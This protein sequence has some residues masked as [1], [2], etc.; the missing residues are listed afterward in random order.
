[1]G[2]GEASS[3]GRRGGA[4]CCLGSDGCRAACARVFKGALATRG[5]LGRLLNAGVLT[6]RRNRRPEPSVAECV[7]WIGWTAGWGREVVAVAL[8]LVGCE[9]D[10]LRFQVP[11]LPRCQVGEP[12]GDLTCLSCGARLLCSSS[13]LGARAASCLDLA[14]HLPVRSECVVRSTMY[15]G[16]VMVQQC[17][18]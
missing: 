2:I 6:H 7:G 11:L 17:N 14:H 5:E 3:R 13:S 15:G 9:S 10:R 16:L 12:H 8:R 18:Y 4:S 1:M